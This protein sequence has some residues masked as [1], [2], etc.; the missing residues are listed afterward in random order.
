MFLI[1]IIFILLFFF[2]IMPLLEFNYNKNVIDIYEN[3]KDIK[4]IDLNKCSKD[5][6]NIQWLDNPELIGTDNGKL[7]N[8]YVSSNL[9]C[10]FGE[11]SGCVC[12][13]KDDFNYLS[14]RGQNN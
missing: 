3:I 5:C 13:K 8:D 1:T 11:N 9:S 4:K 14:N 10:N 7:N 2:F 6:C 12:L